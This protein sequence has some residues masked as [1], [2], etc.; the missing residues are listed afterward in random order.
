MN[1]LV[2]ALNG[3]GM[4]DTAHRMGTLW[5]RYGVTPFKMEAALQRFVEILS[6]FEVG[7]TFPIT[8]VAL[9]RTPRVLEKYGAHG[10]EFAVHGYY[11]LDHSLMEPDRLVSELAA[12]RQLFDRMELR[13][14]GF[15]APYLRLKR[16]ALPALSEMGFLYDSSESLAWDV[17]SDAETASYRRALHFYGAQPAESFPALPRIENGMVE[18]PYCLPDDEA[19]VERLAFVGDDAVGRPWL[20]MLEETYHLGE[21][22][23]LGLHPER[24]FE[25]EIPLRRVLHAAK[26][27]SPGVWIARLE[28]ISA[29][30]KARAEIDWKLTSVAS[31]EYHL[32]G[33]YMPGLA[34][35]ARNI[36]AIDHVEEWDDHYVQA[37]G[38]PFRFR[39]PSVPVI[40]ITQ[41]S[42]PA[43]EAFLRQQGYLVETVENR[44]NY[45]ILLHR[46]HFRRKDERAV[47]AEVERCDAPLVR[48]GRWPHAARS[49]LCVSGDVDALTIWDYCLR[50]LGR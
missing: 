23:T 21:L 27:H 31:D 38:M 37:K 25:C 32:D 50:L 12:A 7:G 6:Q 40:G 35:L 16:D 19:L 44:R 2:T 13:G 42:H 3:K 24:I 26:S 17:A 8:A 39:S 45:S 30:W 41:M 34:L 49:A 20:D 29:W 11:H 33:E 48:L 22:F 46:P 4:R 36:E 14:A 15:R 10:I 18:I 1:A 5:G 9:Q 43:L 47:L 28:E